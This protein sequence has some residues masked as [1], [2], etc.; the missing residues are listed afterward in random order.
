MGKRYTIPFADKQGN[1]YEVAVYQ[2]GY[3]GAVEEL[4]MSVSG[5]VV[6]GTDENF[7]YTPIRTSTANLNVLDK[8]VLTDL[9]SINNQYAQVKLLKN[10]KLEWTG[11]ISPEQYTQPYRPTVQSVS[12]DCVSAIQTLENIEYK[13]QTESGF[14][15]LLALLR[16]LIAS[17]NGGYRGVY[18]PSVYSSTQNVTDTQVLEEMEVNEDNFV[19]GKMTHYDVLAAVMKL[20][21]WTLHDIRGYL[22]IVDNDYK[23]TYKLYDEALSEYT[24]ASWPTARVQ[25]IGYNG[26][27]VNT[28]DVVPGYN[29]ATV[30][31]INNVFDQVINEE[32]Y[33]WLEVA[34]T[35]KKS[36][37][38][39]GKIRKWE[40]R[41]LRPKFFKM[42]YYPY[43]GPWDGEL[44][45]E[46]IE[47]LDINTE[48][49]G[50]VL[51]QMNYYESKEVDGEI[52]PDVKEFTWE[53]IIQIE[54][55]G[56]LSGWRYPAFAVKG[57]TSV[58]EDGALAINFSVAFTK[59]SEKCEY[60]DWTV[61]ATYPCK[62][63]IGDHYWNGEEWVKEESTFD[64]RVEGIGSNGY[65]PL[66]GNKRPDMPYKG[67]DGYII[68]LPTDNP[69]IGQLE[70]E[71]PLVMVYSDVFTNGQ[72]IKDFK[73][74]YAKRDGERDEG[75]NGDRVYEN[76]VNED[77]MSEADEINFEIGSYN[78]DG[79]TYS[80]VLLNGKFLTDQ[81]FCQITD[82]TI[83]PEELMIRRIVNRYKVTKIKLTEA[84]WN[85]D[86]LTPITI[87]I[88]GSQP[89]KSFLMTG[90]EWD[91]QQSRVTLWM[92]EDV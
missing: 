68:P 91:Y 78:E 64:L 59:D 26:A 80:K 16:H 4:R 36:E 34:Q 62:L 88:E 13:Q 25:N 41:F 77:Y 31:S 72:L 76:I 66:K 56:L 87:L 39:K 71:F 29:K 60:W 55:H 3:S 22:Y 44:T 40:K 83:R 45:Q 63:K 86:I 51:A 49:T 27:D 38:S 65:L 52:V 53:N 50:A 84:I 61:G 28:L 37:E 69:L 15:T 81:L 20:M 79:A 2:K 92:Q 58:W 32:D 82:T 75:E 42:Y 12:I 11:Y 89:D 24:F 23:G 70:F 43:E 17:A 73:I 14:I 46:Q 48:I 5:F 33:D 21:N 8:N 30:K 10:G 54:A 90:G 18:I 67:L 9:Y 19:E 74:D 57:K 47:Q 6:T 35:F 1:K 7:V 85:D